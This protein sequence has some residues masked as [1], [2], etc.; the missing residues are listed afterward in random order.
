MVKKKRRVIEIVEFKLKPNYKEEQ[1]KRAS[2]KANSFIESQPGF[3]HRMLLNLKS[4]WFEFTQWRN[5]DFAK[6]ARKKIKVSPECK[7]MIGM[8]SPVSIKVSHPEL[9]QMY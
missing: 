1:I 6:D 5:D 4:K 3:E 8:I 2:D 7:D 9:V